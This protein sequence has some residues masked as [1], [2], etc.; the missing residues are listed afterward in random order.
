MQNPYILTVDLGTSGPKV[1]L[2]TPDGTVI[3][4]A[5]EP[6]QIFLLPNGGA[7]QNPKEWWQSIKKA[8]KR[9]ISET[10]IDP[11]Q[12]TAVCCTSQWSGTVAV[13]QDG[14]ALLNAII[15]MDA[16]GLGDLKPVIEGFPKV[17]GY[18]LFKLLQWLRKTG[19]APSRS[20]KDPVAHIHYI[21]N[22]YPNE[23]NL[24]YRFLEPKDYLNLCFTG[25]FA[26][27]YDSI[28]LH[29][30]TD[31]RDIN[32]IRYD[33]SLFKITQLPKE[34]LPVLKSSVDVLG[35]VKQDVA[36]ELGLSDDVK[37]VMGTPDVHSA[38]VGSGA[39]QDYEAHLYVGTSSW[40]TCHV[41]FKMTSL[42]YNMAALPSAIPGKYLLMNEQETSGECLDF[43]KD[44]L[45]YAKDSFSQEEAPA[46][47]Y[48]RL[49]AV[50]AESPAGSNGI[51]FTPWLY[52]E[53]TPIEDH[54]VRAG[55]FN[56]S[57]DNTRA[58][59][60]RSVMEGVACNARWLLEV[61]EKLI[62]QKLT[63]INIVGGG[64]RSDVWCQIYADVLNRPIR[65]MEDP[66]L[67][68]LRGACYLASVALG[69]TSFEKISRTAKVLKEYTPNPAHTNLYNKRFAHFKEIYKRNKTLYK[70]L[71]AHV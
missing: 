49:S 12:I 59:I 11:K 22:K 30:V 42:A 1:A 38:A 6:N 15:W 46:D 3:G 24:T 13:D 71:N 37:V 34:K 39:V 19:G 41:P 5:S 20:G 45:F 47:F 36:R 43:L 50:A 62:K 33:D 4:H 58:D 63:Y 51:I 27:S 21:K 31:N 7:E 29:W 8:I 52:G 35:V 2:F 23:Y 66:V 28:T 56:L 68:N 26:S 53:R 55:F 65:Q 48:E 9:L 61:L 40:L 17:E 64:A 57:L 14:D 44:Q 10:H 16:R 70:K 32:N 60:I 25:E 69:Y 67:V 54:T 18:N